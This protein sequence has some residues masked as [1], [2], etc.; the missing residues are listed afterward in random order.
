MNH[1]LCLTCFRVGWLTETTSGTD[2]ECRRLRVIFLFSWVMNSGPF[3]YF[4][5]WSQLIQCMN[6][7]PWIW[8]TFRRFVAKSTLVYDREMVICM[9]FWMKI[10]WT[11]NFLYLTGFLVCLR[12]V[13]SWIR[14]E[15]SGMFSCWME[16][17]KRFWWMWLSRLCVHSNNKFSD[18][19]STTAM[20]M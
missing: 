19:T 4:V 15:K 17:K 10:S 3:R 8:S 9:N 11:T 5:H 1:G 18:L 12:D 13:F 7:S 14:S 6:F 2:K 16:W 20:L